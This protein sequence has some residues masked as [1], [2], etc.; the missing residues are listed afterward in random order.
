[1][2]L[3]KLE[4]KE[5][6]RLKRKSYIAYRYLK[7]YSP[8]VLLILILLLSATIIQ[9]NYL[10]KP[11]RVNF[12]ESPVTIKPATPKPIIVNTVE[13]TPEI[14]ENPVAIKPV[15]PKPI[16]ANNVE[17]TP[18]NTKLLLLKS[19]LLA[20]KEK[21]KE[22]SKYLNDQEQ[23]LLSSL[24]SINESYK[25][26][27][28]DTTSTEDKVTNSSISEINQ[29]EYY[30]KVRSALNKNTDNDLKKLST[31]EEESINPKAI[32]KEG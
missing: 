1:M 6:Y 19:E 32:K 4:P 30:N 7:H 29:T 24:S 14:T 2:L 28:K 23:Q 26:V 13:K 18:E 9:K 20:E 21:N 5:K 12:V 16:I 10:N 27:L 15:T 25:S 17:K 22:F 3:T 11:K 8:R 31:K